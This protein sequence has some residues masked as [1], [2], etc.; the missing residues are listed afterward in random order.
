MGC[1][2]GYLKCRGW[3]GEYVG[4]DTLGLMVKEARR[5]Y[6]GVFFE[7][8]DILSSPS[9]RKCDYVFISGIFN[10]KV[11]DNWAWVEQMIKKALLLS[12]RGVAFNILNA[13]CPWKDE[14][15]FYADPTVLEEKVRLW[16][17]GKYKILDSYLPGED[18][19]VYLYQ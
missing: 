10:H 2:Y 5:R 9:V 7:K 1:L 15:L 14:D 4:F 3:Q 6:P 13:N 17:G 8:R 19:T 16:S 11:K 12:N 18:L